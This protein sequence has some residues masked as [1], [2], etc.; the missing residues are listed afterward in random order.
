MEFV[1]IF[2]CENFMEAFMAA[3]KNC[4]ICGVYQRWVGDW[5]SELKEVAQLHVVCKNKPPRGDRV[6]KTANIKTNEKTDDGKV[7]VINGYYSSLVGISDRIF[8]KE[9]IRR[10]EKYRAKFIV[11]QG[12]QEID[13]TFVDIVSQCQSGDYSFAKQVIERYDDFKNPKTWMKFE[14]FTPAIAGLINKLTK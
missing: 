12:R 4:K 3:P 11:K 10:K 9:Q 5:E 7:N 1:L 14:Y 8:G 13:I 2:D 6:R